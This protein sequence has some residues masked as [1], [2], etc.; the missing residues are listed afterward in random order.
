[1]MRRW[2]NFTTVRRRRP[3]PPWTTAAAPP[4]VLVPGFIGGNPR[5]MPTA[6]RGEFTVSPPAAPVVVDRRSRRPAAMLLA[7]RGEFYLTPFP[8]VV[9]AGP[10]PLVP[11]MR[12]APHS[13]SLPTR[14]TLFADPPWPQVAPA[15]PP[16][17]APKYL[18]T[19]TR[20]ILSRRAGEYLPVPPTV[21]LAPRW[22]GRRTQF[23]PVRR[24]EFLLFAPSPTTVPPVPR[25]TSRAT[26]TPV[27][28]GRFILFV[29][30]TVLP[31]APG[32]PPKTASRRQQ[33][34]AVRRG[35]FQ[36]LPLVGASVG[37]QLRDITLT[38]GQLTTGWTTGTLTTG[39]SAGELGTGWT[40]GQ[41]EV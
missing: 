32:V 29:S 28:R 22:A 40:T 12:R 7:R 27:R 36:S 34:A 23:L 3:D 18:R 16:A 6:R 37:P 39:W 2:R 30:P 17:M 25:R 4:P 1:M 8:A 21:S 15:P 35:R 38:L 9:P 31:V 20:P 5:W 19:S 13:Y 26:V 33:L 10:A 24:G 11:A 14:A 41:L